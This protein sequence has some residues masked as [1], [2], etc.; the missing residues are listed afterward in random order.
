MG[1]NFLGSSVGGRF[2]DFFGGAGGYFFVYFI[3]FIAGF[4]V[5]NIF[6]PIY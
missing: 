1:I 6:Y 2:W 5:G 4:F 3:M